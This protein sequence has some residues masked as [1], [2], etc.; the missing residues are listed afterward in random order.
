MTSQQD[1]KGK[2]VDLGKDV[3][4][5]CS[6]TD[7]DKVLGPVSKILACQ[8]RQYQDPQV[9]PDDWRNSLVLCKY[10]IYDNAQHHHTV[11]SA[12]VKNP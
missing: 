10:H 2:Y 8:I 4:E 5:I 1:N 9:N 6:R 11:L 3:E 7:N 12:A